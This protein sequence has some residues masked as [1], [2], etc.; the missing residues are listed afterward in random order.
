[1]FL[2]RYKNLLADFTTIEGS[3]VADGHNRPHKFF[4][5]RVAKVGKLVSA[6]GRADGL[7]LVSG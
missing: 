2:T 1:M 5:R 3:D 4:G 7:S 6:A